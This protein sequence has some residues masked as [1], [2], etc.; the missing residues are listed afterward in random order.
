MSLFLRYAGAIV[1]AFAVSMATAFLF[2]LLVVSLQLTSESSS[3]LSFVGPFLFNALMGFAGVLVG[4]LCLPRLH[5]VSGAVVLFVLGVS[6]EIL[7]FTTLPGS[8]AGFPRGVLATA[9]GGLIAVGL[10]YWRRRP[11]NSV[12]PTANRSAAGDG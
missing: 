9:P 3:V 6:F 4:A 7:F 10:H 1:V 11:N 8:H 5:R 2:G 12:Q